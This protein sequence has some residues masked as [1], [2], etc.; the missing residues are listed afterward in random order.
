MDTTF[1]LAYAVVRI[2]LFKYVKYVIEVVTGS[3]HFNSFLSL[4]L[5]T[6]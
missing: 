5:T 1:L 2:M 6:K 3:D 4:K